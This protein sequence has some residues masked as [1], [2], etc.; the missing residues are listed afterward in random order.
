[1]QGTAGRGL[2]W[3]I[4]AIVLLVVATVV[5]AVRGVEVSTAVGPAPIAEAADPG[6]VF[7]AARRQNQPVGVTSLFTPT[8]KVS[9]QPN[10]TLTAEPMQVKRGDKRTPVDTKLAPAG[11]VVAPKTVATDIV[12]SGGDTP[13]VRFG[14]PG[15]SF[16]LSWPGKL[17]KP[18]LDGDKA[19]YA[20][21]LPGVDLVLKAESTG[22]SQHLVVN[23]P[24]A[25][26][27]ARGDIANITADDQEGRDLPVWWSPQCA[28]L[29]SAAFMGSAAIFVIS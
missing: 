29:S 24:T 11:N 15:Q 10:G 9:A 1:M 23:S 4:A 13:L 14:T 27:E 3:A 8:R 26:V 28:C 6:V 22:F 25:K 16:T 7:A 12:F 17:P 21:V 18:T 5:V 19:T 20:E 2:R